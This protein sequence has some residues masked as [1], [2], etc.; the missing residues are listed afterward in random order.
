MS[1]KGSLR[2]K[3]KL[4]QIIQVAMLLLLKQDHDYDV[5]QMTAPKTWCNLNLPKSDEYK[6][7]NM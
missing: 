4:E 5:I 6:S 1:H 2:K 7:K 3:W